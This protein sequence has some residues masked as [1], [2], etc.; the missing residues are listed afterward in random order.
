M[1]KINGESGQ[2]LIMVALSLTV[3]LGFSALATDVGSLLHQRRIAQAA[4][5]SAAVAGATAALSVE[6]GSSAQS[7]A[8]TA[9]QTD[10]ALYGF[11]SDQVTIN[12]PPTD[13]VNSAF[14]NPGYVEAIVTETVPTPIITTF[15]HLANPNSTYKGMTVAARAV[16]TDSIQTNPCMQVNNPTRYNPGGDLGGNSLLLAPNC[17]VTV[18]GNLAMSGSSTVNAGALGVAGSINFTGNAASVPADTSTG[19]APYSDPLAILSQPDM[20]PTAGT[21]QGGPCGT[22]P[23]GSGTCTY[24]YQGGNLSGDLQPGVYYF[25]VPVNITGTLTSK[26]GGVTLFL[27]GNVAFDFTNNGVINVTAPAPSGKGATSCLGDPNPY[28]G[29]LIDAPT[30][31]ASDNSCAKG[32]GGNGLVAGTL[33]FDFGSSAVT[34]NGIVYAPQAHLFIQDQG[35]HAGALTIT[36]DFDIGTLC[37]QSADATINGASAIS[38]V[39]Q[40]GLVE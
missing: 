8:T 15:V 23:T 30:D 28:C 31:V 13:D 2:T 3:L 11:S 5:D 32:K 6:N 25:D 26:E 16:A 7:V 33:Y 39:T 29:V 20:A 40:V 34:L 4:A 19:N 9:G 21:K 24:D 37:Q 27:D 17:T 10:A 1:K 36:S 38:R 35:A 12:T 22:T 18:N 14:N